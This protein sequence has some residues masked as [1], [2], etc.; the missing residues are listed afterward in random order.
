M[1]KNW[2]SFRSRWRRVFKKVEGTA[3]VFD[4][5]V[6]A[7]PSVSIEPDY[8]RLSQFGINPSNLAIPDANKA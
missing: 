7:G 4:G 5:I 1:I 6:I 2:K 8:N 3:D